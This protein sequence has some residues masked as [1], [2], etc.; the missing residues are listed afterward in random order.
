MFIDSHCHLRHTYT[1][2]ELAEFLN[3]FPRELS[4]LLEIS[5]N[6]AEILNAALLRGIPRILHGCGLYPENAPEFGDAMRDEFLRLISGYPPDAI[7][8]VGMDYHWGYSTPA[9]QETLFRFNIET[10]VSKNLP[11][12][13]HSRDAFDDTFRILTSYSF[14]TPVIFHCFGYGPAE[15]ERLI[16]HG[17]Y[18][19]FAG[20]ITYSKAEPLR[21]AA[22]LVP[23]DRL[24]LETD[25]PYL[26]P[27]PHRGKKNIPGYVRHT[28]EFTAKLLDKDLDVLS[29][30]IDGNFRRIFKL[31]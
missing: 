14:D 29:G 12:I 13:I 27:V 2:E 17:Y 28:Y 9:E 25:A 8:E 31:T 4:Y 10:A 7:G 3:N 30:E 1:P 26:T 11:L 21:E 20:N 23:T 15:A 22:R 24:L 18:L 16:G 19:S 6:N 5:T